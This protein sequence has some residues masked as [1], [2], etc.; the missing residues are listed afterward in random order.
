MFSS[1]LKGMNHL[2]KQLSSI[3]ASVAKKH[4]RSAANYATKPTMAALKAAAP[5]GTEAHRTYRGRLVAPGF[6]SRS[7]KRVTKLKDG[8]LKVS[9]GV[10][11]EAWYGVHFL[12]ETGTKYMKGR[13]WFKSRFIADSP[14]MAG[15][16]KDQ[17]RKRILAGVK[18]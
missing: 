14:K 13:H 17:L 1:D 12:D 9:M 15:R 4:L 6:L 10:K 3:E 11:R 16:F 18:K 5:R 8:K 2:L 7:I